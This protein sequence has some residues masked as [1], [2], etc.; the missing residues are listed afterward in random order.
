VIPEIKR[1]L[2]ATDLSKN[3]RYAFAYAA[4]LAHRYAA[5]ITILHVLEELGPDATARIVDMIGPEQWEEL[6]QNKLQQ[7][8]DRIKER[9]AR[10]CEE[11]TQELPDCPFVTEDIKVKTGNPEEQILLEGNRG[12]YDLIVMGTHGHGTF[13]EAMMGSTARRVLRRSEKP[14]LVVRLPK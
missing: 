3:A 6:Q 12:G 13:A 5:R 8:I 1:I 11:V 7:T 14:V 9:L 10:F 2:Y 4:S